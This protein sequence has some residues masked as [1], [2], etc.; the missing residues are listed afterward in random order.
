MRTN[1]RLRIGAALI[2]ATLVSMGA[3][4]QAP[5]V[6]TADYARAESFLRDKVIPLVSG[7]GVQPIWLSNDRLGYRNPVA[8]AGLSS[9][10]SIPREGPG[11]PAVRRPIVVG[12]RSIL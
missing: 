5:A 4:A 9:F 1:S 12:E 6:T 2:G 3:N 7:M 11:W 10:S 8:V